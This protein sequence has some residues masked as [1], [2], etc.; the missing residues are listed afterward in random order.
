MLLD[1]DVT[2]A[3]LRHLIL[4]QTL[5]R[6]DGLYVIPDSRRTERLFGD[7][8]RTKLVSAGIK[9]ENLGKDYD[10]REDSCLTKL[11]FA[12]WHSAPRNS[13]HRRR[14]RRE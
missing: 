14:G 2:I 6:G 4:T 1:N 10:P 5:R 13:K 8:G 3:T 7:A 9:L 12:C 11:L